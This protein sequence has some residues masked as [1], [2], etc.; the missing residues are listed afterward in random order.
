MLRIHFTVE[1][2]VRTTLVS[3]LDPLW[4]VLLS[5]HMLQVRDG[6]AS[7]GRWRQRT[8]RRVSLETF[9]PLIAL[10]PP[11]GYSPDFLTPSTGPV[12]FEAALEHMLA[13]PG[14]RIRADLS[15]LAVRRSARSWVRELAEA[16]AGSMHRLGNLVRSFH[17]VTL[18][19]HWVSMK[20]AA[21]TDQ[22][23]RLSEL[24]AGGVEAMLQGIHPG[25]RWNDQTLEISA[26]RSDQDVWLE[27]RG[28]RLQPSYFCWG[29]P[30]KLLNAGSAPVLVYPID[31]S[32]PL[33]PSG[34]IATDRHRVLSKLFGNTRAAVLAL[35]VPG[36]TTTELATA[37]NITLA[38]A[39]YQVSILRSAG[40]VESHRQ[41]KFVLHVATPLGRALLDDQ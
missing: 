10:A 32:V 12:V 24:T 29:A 23:R 11:I 13:V 4:E 31:H 36:C 37:T 41:G 21:A 20:A 19:P 34:D 35:T 6:F 1:D 38:T 27:G 15:K 7:F 8:R 5:L 3:D 40:L 16:K 33:M 30:T 17:E 22:R 25:A 2:L 28:L 18:A 26:F 14:H 39:S 9:E